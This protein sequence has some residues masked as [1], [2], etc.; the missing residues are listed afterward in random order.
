M[1]E[2]A[3]LRRQIEIECEAMR[4]AMKGFKI[5]A[6][7]DIINNQYNSIGGLQEQLAAIVGEQEAAKIAVEVYIQAIG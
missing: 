5:T 7:H 6:S 3:L 2:I 1:S 4:Q